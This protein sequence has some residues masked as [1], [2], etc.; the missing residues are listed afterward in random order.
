MTDEELLAQIRS[1]TAQLRKV[2]IEVTPR[3][4]VARAQRGDVQ[5][6]A[7]NGGLLR[8]GWVGR[9]TT[10]AVAPTGDQGNLVT[11]P[12]PSSVSWKP[13]PVISWVDKATG[14]IMTGRGFLIDRSKP[15]PQYVP[16]IRKRFLNDPQKLVGSVEAIEL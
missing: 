2:K 8:R 7:L 14:E 1:I 6:S 12:P 10:G 15:F 4:F 3:G 13:F 9:A 16:D 11:P 5:P